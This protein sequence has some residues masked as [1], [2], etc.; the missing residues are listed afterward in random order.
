LALSGR[1]TLDEIAD[2]TPEQ[3]IT[4]LW[5]SHAGIRDG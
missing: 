1:V 3:I 2:A 4:E 5:R